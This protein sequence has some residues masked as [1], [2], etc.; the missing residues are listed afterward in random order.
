MTNKKGE[1]ICDCGWVVKG[2]S[3]KHARSNFE[4]H[5]QSKLHK[6][7]IKNAKYILKQ[8]REMK[9]PN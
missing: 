7:L 5:K 8:K 2:T 4:I 1:I 3:E 6:R 9:I